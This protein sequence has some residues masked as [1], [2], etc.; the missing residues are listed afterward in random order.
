MNDETEGRMSEAS[1]SWKLELS[2]IDKE[3][4]ELRPKM[5]E[6]SR[7]KFQ[8]DAKIRM[9]LATM[10][11]SLSYDLERDTERSILNL[12]EEYQQ[13]CDGFADLAHREQF[14]K[15]R[16]WGL[17]LDNRPSPMQEWFEQLNGKIAATF[18]L[19]QVVHQVLVKVEE[20][21]GGIEIVPCDENGVAIKVAP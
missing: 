19:L 21:P 5:E 2:P 13:A 17:E 15:W 18:A 4:D 8:L 10:T 16:K 12:T 6:L 14:L 7:L 11:R 9:D 20:P 3:L 1:D